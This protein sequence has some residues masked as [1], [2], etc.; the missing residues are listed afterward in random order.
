MDLAENYT[1]PAIMTFY[2]DGDVEVSFPDLHATTQGEGE[3]NALMRARDFLGLVMYGLEEDGEPIP[4][5]SSL[6]DLQMNP[7]Q[8]SILVDVYMPTIRA[9]AKNAS[10]KRTVS[11]PVY[12]NCL[13]VEKNLNFSQLLQDAIKEKLHIMS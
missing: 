8:R 4:E 12:L 7:D 13:A 9:K 6:S 5:P 10:M 1:Y 3:R 2:E 11:L